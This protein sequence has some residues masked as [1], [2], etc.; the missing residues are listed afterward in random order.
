MCKIYRVWE[1][2]RGRE[3]VRIGKKRAMWCVTEG[4][5]C[6]HY[7]LQPHQCTVCLKHRHRKRMVQEKS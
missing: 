5:A 6:C 4:I 1:R 3:E 2:K 7:F